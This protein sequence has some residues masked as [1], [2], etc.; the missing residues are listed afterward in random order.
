MT[1][2][3]IKWLAGKYVPVDAPGLFLSTVKIMLAPVIGSVLAGIWRLRPV[4]LWQPDGGGDYPAAP[5][6]SPSPGWKTRR[7]QHRKMPAIPHP[8]TG[9]FRAFRLFRRPRRGQKRAS[10]FQNLA[11]VFP[12]EPLSS[13]LTALRPPVTCAVRFDSYSTLK[14]KLNYGS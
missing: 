11:G 10:L 12:G 13:S 3:R 5:L 1:P 8:A 9:R 2:L 6:K 4:A 7:G 14:L